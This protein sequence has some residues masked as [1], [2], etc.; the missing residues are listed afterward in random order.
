[1][2][3][4]RKQARRL[5]ILKQQLASAGPTA[6]ATGG[7]I[8]KL[9][10]ANRGEIAVRIARAASELGIMSV[11]VYAEDDAQSM[12]VFRADESHSLGA[13]GVAAYLDIEAV[14]AV[15]RRAGCDAVHPGYGFL[16][17]NAAFACSV[18][19][20][21][22][23]FVGPRSETIALLGDKLRCKALA[24]EIGVPLLPGSASPLT[25]PASLRALFA[26]LGG[27]PMMVK[28]VGGGGGR[29]MRAVFEADQLEQAFERCTSEALASCGDGALFAEQLLLR[30]RHIEVQ[31][32]GDGQGGPGS[33]S[34]LYE[35]DCSVQRNHQKLVEVAPCPA[36]P[37]SLR[38]RLLADAV[39]LTQAAG[40]RSAGT[41][42]FLVEAEA[43]GSL[44]GA[45]RHFLMEV[46]PRL[47][48][49]HTVTE[50]ISGVDIVQAQLRLAAAAAPPSSPS[51]ATPSLRELG[52]AQADIPPPRG[53]AIQARVNMERMK[54]GPAAQGS[55][56]LALPAAGGTILALQEPAGPGVRVDGFGYAGY[57]TSDKYDSLLAKVITHAPGGTS[58]DGSTEAVTE[59]DAA[60]A[61]FALACAKSRRALLEFHLEGVGSN[62]PLLVGV[63]G[64]P[65]FAAGRA[66]TGFVAAEGAACLAEGERAL[67]TSASKFPP[68]AGNNNSNNNA[69]RAAAAAAAAAAAEVAAGDVAQLSAMNASVVSLAE[70][71]AVGAR[72]RAGDALLVLSGER[73]ALPNAH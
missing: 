24:R 51:S 28:A 41:V 34:H 2:A 19:A 61:A 53:F 33:V 47:Q 38:Q 50:A 10:I 52:L 64:H 71:V 69:A 6:A 11:A 39:K 67:A 5:R 7:G 59:M 31:V 22:I 26:E 25:D 54:V 55:P 42:E 36:M 73:P 20:A 27:A 56:L 15:A 14:L 48:V 18:E 4:S 30:P 57:E 58:G 46:N 35:R 32:L 29:G 40:Y 13:T 1:M 72:V 65:L 44:G 9:L 60:A 37:A 43:D 23:T 17:E 16:S 62:L 45:S 21:G 70:G 68:A 3:G 49:E 12:H 8:R 66:D 63:L